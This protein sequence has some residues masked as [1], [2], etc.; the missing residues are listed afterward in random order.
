MPF[1]M[2]RWLASLSRKKL[3]IH[4]TTLVCDGE[5]MRDKN[6]VELGKKI[7]ALRRAVAFSQEEVAYRAGIDYSFFGRIERGEVNPS[8]LTLLSIAEALGVTP[9]EVLLIN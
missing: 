6:L 3:L 5:V 7:R 2:R 9:F 8:Y 4:L 1:A